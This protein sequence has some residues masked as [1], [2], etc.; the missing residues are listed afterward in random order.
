MAKKEDHLLNT[1][2]GYVTGFKNWEAAAR[3]AAVEN[4]RKNVHGAF[5]A[6][7]LDNVK[8]EWVAE[9]KDNRRRPAIMQRI[10]KDIADEEKAEIFLDRLRRL[11]LEHSPLPPWVD[12]GSGSIEIDMCAQIQKD[13]LADNLADAYVR[14]ILETPAQSTGANG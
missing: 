2:A 8:K 12:E 4:L 11:V 9:A 5:R 1:L 3:V 7:G 10:A 14:D 6:A 13:G